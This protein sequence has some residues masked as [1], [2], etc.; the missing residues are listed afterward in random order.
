M[1][2]LLLNILFVFICYSNAYASGENDIVAICG[3]LKDLKNGVSYVP[4]IDVYGNPV[5]PADVSNAKSNFVNDPVIIP[6]EIDLLDRLNLSLPTEISLKPTVA[7]LHIYKDG[8]VK[9]NGEDVT[10]RALSLCKSKQEITNIP[11]SEHRQNAH[12]PLPS[13]DKIEGQYPG[14][15]KP[16]TPRYNE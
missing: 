10:G 16:N 7:S 3:K 8:Q 4:N 2:R 14:D 13:S 15:V 12:N 1:M 9:Y 6:I 11:Q 5:T